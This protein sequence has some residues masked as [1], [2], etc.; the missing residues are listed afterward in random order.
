MSDTLT[1]PVTTSP[2]DM[3]LHALEE[4]QEKVPPAQRGLASELSGLRQQLVG[5]RSLENDPRFCAQV[6][7]LV[8]DWKQ[9]SG[10][11][12]EPNISP[13]LAAGLRAMAADL[14]GLEQ[15]DMKALLVR[16]GGLQ[17]RELVQNIRHRALE[18]AAL[19][20][21]EQASLAV[22]KLIAVLEYRVDQ[23]FAAPAP[24]A[25]PAAA[26]AASQ[27]P[28]P[29]GP[30]A[31]PAAGLSPEPAPPSGPA[32]GTGQQQAGMADPEHTDDSGYWESVDRELAGDGR[33]ADPAAGLPGE[34]GPEHE[35]RIREAERATATRA[36]GEVPDD[37]Q[38][39]ESTEPSEKAE[40]GK[41]Q[42]QS[43]AKQAQSQSAPTE[44]S[45]AQAGQETPQAAQGA[46]PQA[47]PAP[48]AGFRMP[49]PIAAL[50][51]YAA[52][53]R[54]EADG[55]R[56]KELGD[57]VQRDAKAVVE[58]I[59]SLHSA[60]PDLF[61]KL[62]ATAKQQ[63]ST[64]VQT[65]AEMRAGGRNEALR[66]EFEA[67]FADPVYA[68][69]YGKVETAGSRLLKSVRNLTVEGANRGVMGSAPVKDGEE[70]AGRAAMKLDD[71]PGRKEGKS[72][73]A[74]IGALVEKVAERL[75]DFFS[76]I[77]GE[78]PTRDRDS[79]PSR[80]L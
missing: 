38:G 40:A 25:A 57:R 7:W 31:R 62:D 51:S 21:Q 58:G 13:V 34:N 49:R 55:R 41:R 19:S 50:A 36:E 6:G 14:P 69:A 27:R 20:P 52:D 35:A 53:C 76:R 39:P 11:G 24:Q 16:A 8:Q 70:A 15:P 23:A 64:V 45:P 61:A 37:K 59:D 18:T 43:G 32:Q 42:G 5:N 33:A 9:F 2:L 4:Q 75:R 1:P 54:E 60:A 48:G 67:K 28:A 44:Q 26:H 47:A 12:E 79:G 3:V 29:S 65:I 56:M 63:G 30:E 10:T 71:I 22:A 72:L 73:F 17:D 78:G 68:A 77:R 46:A 74:E 66:K 80:G